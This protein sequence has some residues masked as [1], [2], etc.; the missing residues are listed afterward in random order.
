MKRI[1][2]LS[3]STGGG[4]VKAAEGLLSYRK[5]FG[6]KYHFIHIDVIKHMSFL[7]KKLYADTYLSIINNFPAIYGHLYSMTDDVNDGKKEKIL[8]AKYR[9][10]LEWFFT[11]RFKGIIKHIAPECIIFTHFLPAEHMNKQAKKHKYAKKYAVVVT[12]FDV[13]SLWIQPNMDLFF[14]ANEECKDRLIDKGIQGN[15]IHI[16]GIP[17]DINFSKSYNKEEIKKEIG[18]SPYLPTI[19]I[20]SGAFGVGKVDLFAEDILTKLK[21]DFQIIALTGTNY[22]LYEAFKKLEKKHPH[23][24]HTVK[25]T[26]EVYKY[27]AASDFAITKTGG[28]TSS[29]CLAMGLPIITLN[30]IPGQEQRNTDYLMEHGAGLKAYDLT[31]LR[32][33][34]NEMLSDSE[35]L[36]RMQENARNAAKPNAGEEIL[37]ILLSTISNN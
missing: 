15:K 26:N 18:L 2:I 3:G 24:L 10:V 8:L 29:E 22:E 17:I 25:Y 12:D 14:V 11:L 30:P 1:V 32:F 31:G 23:K 20:M 34:V 4:H 13:H 37:S 36:K 33:R 28:L 35:K 21:H 7:F 16:T 6:N 19:L 9:R 5:K 27:M